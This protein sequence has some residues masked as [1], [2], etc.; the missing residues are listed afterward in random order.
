MFFRALTAKCK[1]RCFVKK[2][3]RDSCSSRELIHYQSSKLHLS[4]PPSADWLLPDTDE[5]LNTFPF[6]PYTFP[7]VSSGYHPHGRKGSHTTYREC[8]D[9]MTILPSSSL[10][11]HWLS[12]SI[13]SCR[14]FNRTFVPEP[15]PLM[16]KLNIPRSTPHIIFELANIPIRI[17]FPTYTTTLFRYVDDRISM[18]S[19]KAWPTKSYSHISAIVSGQYT[20]FPSDKDGFSHG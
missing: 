1:L 12:L 11:L 15:E 8:K 20:S 17:F 6:T 5:G 7:P 13:N 14:C 18:T 9:G 4:N 3:L 10:R 2:I 19:M 16:T